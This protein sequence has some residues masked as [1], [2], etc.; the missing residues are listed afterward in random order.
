MQCESCGEDMEREVVAIEIVIA[1]RRTDHP[2][3]R[4]RLGQMR[5]LVIGT[6]QFER[7]DRLQVFALQQNLVAE[8]A[9]QTGC[10]FEGRLTGHIIDTGLEDAFD[11][12]VGHVASLTQLATAMAKP[13]ASHHRDRRATGFSGPAARLSMISLKILRRLNNHC[14]ATRFSSSS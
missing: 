8:S 6:A 14:P 4:G 7:K 1:G 10:D 12:C 2:A 3:P 5:D 9:R 13:P 11:V